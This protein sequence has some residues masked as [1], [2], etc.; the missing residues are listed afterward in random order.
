MIY[1]IKKENGQGLFEYALII[2]LI[3][4]LFMSQSNHNFV[5]SVKLTYINTFYSIHLA[6]HQVS[7][8]EAVFTQFM[9]DSRFNLD[10]YEYAEGKIRC[11]IHSD[12]FLPEDPGPDPGTI[13]WL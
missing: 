11:K 6:I 5:C 2:S 12:N 1:P 7:D 4:V 8:S 9:E 10:H 13:P 3:A